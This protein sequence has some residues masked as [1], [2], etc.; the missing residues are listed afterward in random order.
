MAGTPMSNHMSRHNISLSTIYHNLSSLYGDWSNLG[1]YYNG[2]LKIHE[3][4]IY[5][6]NIFPWVLKIEP[7]PYHNLCPAHCWVVLK[8]LRQPVTLNTCSPRV[9]RSPEGYK[10]PGAVEHFRTLEPVKIHYFWPFRWAKIGEEILGDEAV[11]SPGLH[12]KHQES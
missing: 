5:I 6:Y 12:T 9:S 10:G 3:Q 11:R 8:I 2:S 4:H 7:N 1:V